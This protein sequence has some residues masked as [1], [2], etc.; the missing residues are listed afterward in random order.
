V[1]AAKRA[2]RL[3]RREAALALRPSLSPSGPAQERLRVA[4]WNLNS[5]RTRLPAVERFLEW[6]RPDI[7]CLHETRAA[8]PLTRCVPLASR[9]RGEAALG[10]VVTSGQ[11]FLA[12][13]PLKRSRQLSA[14]TSMSYLLAAAVIR[15]QAWSR[16]ASVT[17]S[18]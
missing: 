18:T 11:C 17:P 1:P 6:V 7:V 14:E 4:T 13:P 12:L 15:F 16:S 3:E 5:L 2:A 9:M 8:H 10:A